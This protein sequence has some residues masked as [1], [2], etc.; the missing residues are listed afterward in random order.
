MKIVLFF[1]F[2]INDFNVQAILIKAYNPK[3]FFEDKNSFV[4]LNYYLKHEPMFTLSC[5]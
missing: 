1:N 2:F 4:R 5:G 3:L